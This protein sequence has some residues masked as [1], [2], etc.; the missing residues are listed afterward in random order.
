MNEN[1][2]QFRS[3]A[4]GGF[5]RQDVLDHIERL[6]RENQMQTADLEAALKEAQDSRTQAEEN[7]A[8]I[9]QRAECA[10]QARDVLERELSQVKAQL[11]ETSANL[12]E[13]EARVGVLYSQVEELE[14]KAKAWQHLKDTAGDIEI[15]AHERAQIVIQEAHAQAAEIRA[16]GIRWVLDIQHR[17]DKL[18]QDLQAAILAAEMELDSVRGAFSRAEVDM[19]GFQQALSDLISSSGAEIGV[20]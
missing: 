6:T 17:C 18:Q 9:Q 12:I 3:A 16:E 19:D 2:G 14:P 7:L 10:E 8:E 11:K 5:H 1:A 15:G 13:A 4:F 20:R